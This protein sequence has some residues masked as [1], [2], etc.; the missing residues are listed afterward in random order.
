MPRP[1]GP[2]S[3]PQRR[4]ERQRRLMGLDQFP[5]GSKSDI[6]KFKSKYLAKLHRGADKEDLDRAY[7]EDVAPEITKFLLAM[8]QQDRGFVGLAHAYRPLNNKFNKWQATDGSIINAPFLKLIMEYIGQDA[9]DALCELE[10]LSEH[11]KE[12]TVKLEPFGQQE[13]ESRGSVS[14]KLIKL[15]QEVKK[16][17]RHPGSYVILEKLIN[18]NKAEKCQR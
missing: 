16:G 9:A 15:A 18:K 7:E 14:D 10:P 6:E 5:L 17:G 1:K 12:L 8:K 13:F 2:P 11:L 4:R 3:G